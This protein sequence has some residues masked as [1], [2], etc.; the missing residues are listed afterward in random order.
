MQLAIGDV[1]RDRTDMELATVAGVAGQVGDDN[2]VVLQ[3]SGGELRRVKPYDLEVVGRRPKMTT[4]G[5][6]LVAL[7]C[8]GIA[9][10]AGLLGCQAASRG[11][12]LLSVLTG[13]GSYSAVMALLQLYLR[14]TGPRR[15]RI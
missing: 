10:I 2:L 5:R 1:V 3:L 7:A 14:I 6:S 8:M 15:I 9:V 11:G 4:T 13:F 12:W